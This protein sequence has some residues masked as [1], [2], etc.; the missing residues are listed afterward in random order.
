MWGSE[1]DGSV[2]VADAIGMHRA[3]QV[4]RRN[5]VAMW[6]EHAFDFVLVRNTGG[7]FVVNDEIVALGVIRITQ[8][9]QRGFGAGVIRVN[10]SNNDIG[11][12]FKAL[13]ENI[14]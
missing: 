2:L 14:F 11:A 7:A 10:L 13:L 3:V 1:G 5:A 12:F 9:R 6:F 8:N 4:Y